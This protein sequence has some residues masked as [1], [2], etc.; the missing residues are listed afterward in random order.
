[1]KQA[2]NHAHLISNMKN[3]KTVS[4]EYCALA[5][6]WRED[7]NSV[8]CQSVAMVTGQLAEDNCQL[9]ADIWHCGSIPDNRCCCGEDVGPNIEVS[10]C[11]DREV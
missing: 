11:T 2:Y 4:K 5:A 3:G 1:M 9:Q 7:G 10:V 8:Q 6:T